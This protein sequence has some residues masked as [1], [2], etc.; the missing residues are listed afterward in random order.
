[1]G[2]VSLPVAASSVQAGTATTVN[3]TAHGL[4]VGYTIRITG[5]TGDWATANGVWT[6]TSAN[7][8]TFTF[9]L[10]SHGFNGTF[11]GTIARTEFI[12]DTTWSV[13]TAWQAGVS[14]NGTQN[15][16]GEVALTGLAPGG[17]VLSGDSFNVNSAYSF[18][19]RCASFCAPGSVAALAD[20]NGR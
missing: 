13:G 16:S 4:A 11:N 18:V 6:L 8:N 12:A 5:A 1:P 3:A 9:A 17:T 10:D 2:E 19:I 20:A 15:N 14:V 7:A